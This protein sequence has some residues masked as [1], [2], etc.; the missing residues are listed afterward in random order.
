MFITAL[1]Q[2]KNLVN[3]T[4]VERTLV[5]AQDLLF[6]ITPTQGRKLV[7]VRSGLRAANR[8]Q[9]F[10]GIRKAPWET[11][12]IKALNVA[13]CSS[14][15]H[16]HHRVHTGEMPYTCDMCGK[17]F[18]FRSLLCIHQGVHTGKRP[19]NMH[20][21]WEGLRS[22]LQTSCP[23]EGPY[24]RE[25]TNAASAANAS[26]PAPSSKST[27]GC[28]WGRSPPLWQVWKGLQPKHT[29]AHSPEVHTGETLQMRRV[30]E[31]FLLQLVSAHSPESSHGR[32]ALHVPSVR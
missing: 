25:T 19:Y 7:R 2:E 23:S 10:P 13:K 22:E 14:S 28:T 32:K 18:G 3:M 5:R 8:A 6:T 11:N 4:S 17:G 21:V 30:Q 24:W 15:L 29:P 31:G 9:T 26:A 27:G 1:T 16:N 12:P 20:R